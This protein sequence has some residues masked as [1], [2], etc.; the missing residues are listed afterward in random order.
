MNGLYIIVGIVGG[1]FLAAASGQALLGLVLGL[2]VGILFERNAELK[3]QIGELA[4]HVSTL[5]ARTA[6]TV[7]GETPLP[8]DEPPAAAAELPEEHPVPIAPLAEPVNAP[9]ETVSKPARRLDSLPPEPSPI[10]AATKAALNW[11]T[12]GN[13]PAKIGVLLSFIG[14]S[15]LLKYA[16]DR[17]L[18]NLPIELRLLAVAL[19]GLVMMGI[20]WRLRERRRNYGLSL[21]GGGAG[22]LFI[23]VFAALRIWQLLPEPVAF[24]LLFA[25]AAATGLLAVAQNAKTLALFGV[26]GGFLAPLLASTG[27]GSHVVLFS[28]Y[29]VINLAILGIAWYRAW[30]VLNLVGFA[31]TFVISCFWGYRYF[32]PELFAST[33]PFLVLFFLFYTAIA[34]LYALRQP[35]EKLGLVD[36]TLVFGT[37]AIAFGLQSTLV[38]DSEYGLATSAAVLAVF[39]GALT[40]WLRRR[41]GEYLRLLS[42]SF[43][44][45]AVV[46]GTV[47]IP[48]ALDARWTSAAWA[49]EGAGLVWIG[50]R[51]GRHLANLAGFALV[52]L[53]GISFASDGWREGSGLVLL[54]GNVGGGLMVSLAALFV[55]RRFAQARFEAPLAQP[56]AVAAMFAFGWGVAWWLGTGWWEIFDR[57]TGGLSLPVALSFTALSAAASVLVGDKRRWGHMQSATVILL[58][59]LVL[60]ALWARVDFGHFLHGWGWLAWPVALAAQAYVLWGLDRRQSMIAATWHMASLV[61]L[62]TLAVFE[63]HWRVERFASDEWALSASLAMA[64]VAALAIRAGQR[65]LSW[66]VPVHLRAYLHAALVLA[67]FQAA[68]LAIVSARYPGDAD[69][70]PYLAVLNPFGLGLLFSAFTA[71]VALKI[72]NTDTALDKDHLKALKSILI[73]AFFVM[74]T[75]ATVRAVHQFTG[76]PWRSDALFGS[77]RVQAVLSIYW[78]LLGFAGMVFGARRA[79]RAAWLGGAALMAVVVIK[80]FLVDL[81]NSGTVERIV[82]FIGTGALLLVVGYFAPVPPRK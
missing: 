15:F 24:V 5:L 19:A 32:R 54:N 46:F 59:L 16:I 58:P 72:A 2:L 77:D 75:A 17:N 69:P 23:T 11:V 27:Q 26:T 29:L 43:L 74:T 35:P 37:P 20:G 62:V 55:S 73:A 76:V 51:Q 28:Y 42:E 18:F 21:Q 13:I 78:G 57:A 36:G 65:R 68:S 33:E 49:L 30:R 61:L 34:I 70:L 14:V 71:W 12:T 81:G 52:I 25:V 10:E 38:H 48:L 3:R 4:E 53:A 31:F 6:P 64:G 47:A 63:V 22:I 60:F 67:V 7:T 1:L 9:A 56:Y 50:M 66:P 8:P 41:R 79:Q 45:L 80:L 39:Y 40:T 44:S 82:S